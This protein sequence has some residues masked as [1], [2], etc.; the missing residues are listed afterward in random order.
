MFLLLKLEV[1]GQ[2]EAFLL[3]FMQEMVL[4][5][6]STVGDGDN[7]ILGMTIF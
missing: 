1:E 4:K 6:C 3:S 7:G 2:N 5:G